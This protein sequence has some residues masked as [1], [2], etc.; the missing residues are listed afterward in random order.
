[1]VTVSNNY[2]FSSRLLYLPFKL[3][4]QRSEYL[5]IFSGFPSSA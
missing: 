3:N 4:L 2:K 5:L 1:M